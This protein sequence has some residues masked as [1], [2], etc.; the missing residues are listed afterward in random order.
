MVTLRSSRS[1]LALI[2][3]VAASS[4]ASAQ[5]ITTLIKDG[6]VVPGVGNV[7]AINNVVSNNSGGWMVEVDTDGPTTTDGAV[8]RNGSLFM[9]EGFVPAGL[10]TGTLSSWDT[11]YYNNAGTYNGNVFFSGTGSLS[12]D[13]AV[14]QETGMVLREGTIS[15]SPQFSPN[16]PYIGFFEAPNNDVNQVAVLASVDDPAI[17]TT[18]DRAI[19]RWN[20]SPGGALTGETV[21]LKEGDPLPGMGGQ[22]YVD[23]PGTG[24]HNFAFNNL[25]HIMYSVDGDGAT[26]SDTAVFV[27]NAFVMREGDP[28]IVAGRNWGAVGSTTRFDINNSGQWVIAGF[29]DATVTTND[30]II[31]K[32]GGTKVIQEGDSL[33]AIGG[34]F[35]FTGFGSGA[36]DIDDVGNV[37]WFGDWNDPDTTRD[38]GI[39]MNDQLL[40]QKG[41]T[42]IDGQLLTG[43]SGVQDN[44]RVSDNGLFLIFE[45]QLAGGVD[46]AFMVAIPE[47]A[48]AGLAS[49][50]ALALLARRRSR[51][52]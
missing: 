46:G 22:L 12:N 24:P 15:T 19:V 20:V 10:G 1:S 26:T 50:G 17:P 11:L 49:V 47:P 48:A 4:T 13:S 45:G 36:V 5:S 29:L 3:A 30:N 39:F 14:L 32:S 28:S 27:N 9:Q 8:V 34:V 21:V 40:V 16:T 43:L 51:G 41:V 42:M 52:A 7:T 35:T 38:T 23:S 25:G 33:T 37:F 18:V 6:D 31:F 44:F 2:L